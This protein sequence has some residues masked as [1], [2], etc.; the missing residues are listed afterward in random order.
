M[1]VY[2]EY[3]CHLACCD[4]GMDQR[5]WTLTIAWGTRARYTTFDGPVIIAL[6]WPSEEALIPKQN[7]AL[8]SARVDAISQNLLNYSSVDDA[9]KR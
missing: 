6:S 2:V 4:G 9:Y 5:R 8:Q 1:G 3:F 7:L